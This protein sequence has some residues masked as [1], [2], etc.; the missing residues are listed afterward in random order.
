MEPV[1][2]VKT[3]F[4]GSAGIAAAEIATPLLQTADLSGFVQIVVQIVIGV[5]TLISMF[6]KKKQ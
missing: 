1:N 4:A 6:K 5:A 3:L 2:T